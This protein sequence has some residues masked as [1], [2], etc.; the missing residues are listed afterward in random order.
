MD[1][2]LTPPHP[3]RLAARAHR[4]LM[5]ASEDID[6]LTGGD[7][8]FGVMLDRLLAAMPGQPGA[9][10]YD[11]DR[12]SG[13]GSSDPTGRGATQR[14]PEADLIR[15]AAAAKRIRVDADELVRAAQRHHPRHAG[16]I[17]RRDAA[18]NERHDGCESCAR[19]TKDDGDPEFSPVEKGVTDD[20]GKLWQLCS[21]C[22]KRL[23]RCRDTYGVGVVPPIEAVERHAR[24]DQR[25]PLD[26]GLELNTVGTGCAFA[27]RERSA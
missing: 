8:R 22:R 17:D 7:D 27:W 1:D 6:R 26:L 15:I 25:I 16:P 24:G 5:T 21:W 20:E 12:V 23:M 9:A 14:G 10:S 2:T 3:E 4:D 18:S 13:G 19:Y 11:T